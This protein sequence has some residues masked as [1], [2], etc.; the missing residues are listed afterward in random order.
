M[1]AKPSS[2]LL[3]ADAYELTAEDKIRFASE[4]D[5]G[6]VLPTDPVLLTVAQAIAPAEIAAPAVQDVVTLLLRT[7][8]GQ[9]HTRS[10][11]RS[12]AKGRM[13]VGLAAPQVGKRLCIIVI[14]TKID[15]ERKKPGKLEC[16]INPEIIWRSRET[17]EGREGCFSAG[18]VW[19][20]VRRPIA[21]KIRAYAPD[22]KQV[23]H[24]FEGFTAR[25][26]QHEIDHLHGIRFPERITSDRKRHW[27]HTDELKE[28]P[29][30]MHHWHRICTRARWEAF[31]QGKIE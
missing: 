17:E 18:P 9:Q 14:D 22:G 16:F 28:Y 15:Q 8:R 25:I 7:A 24:I 29:K 20:L 2:K 11:A 4:A 27:V 5:A 30:A 26:V 23:E 6:M 19:G 21:V 12:L 10:K 13:L 3:P 1:P 31:K